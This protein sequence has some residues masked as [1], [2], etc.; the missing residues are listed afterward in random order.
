MALMIPPV[1]YGDTNSDGELR[2]F[3]ALRDDPGAADWIVLHSVNLAQHVSNISG[4]A[5]FVVIAPGK[6]ILVLEVKGCHSL[7]RKDGLWFYGKSQDGDQRGPFRQASEAMH[8]L[9]KWLKGRVPGLESV[10]FWSACVF[11]FTELSISSP[12]WHPW[13]VIDSRQFSAKPISQLLA[14]VLDSARDHAASKHAPWAKYSDGAPTPLLARHA[15]RVLRPN[16]EVFSAKPRR[17]DLGAELSAFTDQ[18]Y[19]VLD[20]LSA[21][22]RL[23]VEGPAG[24]GK[25]VLAVEMARRLTANPGSPRVLL[26]CFNRLLGEWLNALPPST[27]G[28]A[29]GCHLHRLM[30]DIAGLKAEALTSDDFYRHALPRVARQEFKNRQL[31]KFDVLVI[32][33]AQDFME[34]DYVD[35]LGSVLDGGWDSGRWYAFGDFQKQAIYGKNALD[36]E[37]GLDHLRTFG[38]RVQLKSNCRNTP[39]IAQYVRLL[40][41]LN[42]DYDTVLRPDDKRSPKLRFYSMTASGAAVLAEETKMLLAEGYIPED[43]IVLSSRNDDDCL[44]ARANGKGVAFRP[45]R[46]GEPGVRYCTIHAFKGLEA[47]AVIVTDV[48]HVL[49]DVAQELFYV[50]ITRAQSRLTVISPESLKQDVLKIV[51]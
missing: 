17:P 23:I 15:A 28:T 8:S 6:G 51:A 22:P 40:G 1:P 29:A 34:P 5:D 16:F 36:L 37:L 13:Q 30:L 9:R 19:R 48:S 14:Q 4:E 42:P 47:P 46:S 12:E 50:G 35:F 25:S 31:P 20:A 21:N 44:A 24:S 27:V 18:Q 45:F 10:L 26:T 41:G 11:P 39:R 38:V 2:V 33:E 43:I 3:E 32:D 49:G 7:S